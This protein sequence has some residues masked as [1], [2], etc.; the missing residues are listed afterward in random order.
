MQG[1]IQEVRAYTHGQGELE[2]VIDGYRPCHNADDVIATKDYHPV[3][4]LENTPGSVF[5]AHGAGYPVQWEDVPEA[6]HVEYT[7][8]RDELM[9]MTNK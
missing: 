7:Y 6:A 3:S 9:K 2:C 5:C 4:D 8:S 1:Y